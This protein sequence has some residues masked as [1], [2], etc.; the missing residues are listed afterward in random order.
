MVGLKLAITLIMGDHFHVQCL[1][2]KRCLFSI[3]KKIKL[4]LC[5]VYKYVNNLNI[6]IKDWEP[7]TWFC[8]KEY[9]RYYS[10]SMFNIKKIIKNKY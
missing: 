4:I 1:I 3:S 8:F 7:F 6:S 9:I 2:F 5:N 10:W